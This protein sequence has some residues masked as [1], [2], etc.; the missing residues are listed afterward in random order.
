VT[1]A[2]RTDLRRA[3]LRFAAVFVAVAGTALAIYS[4]PYAEYGLR[5][6]WFHRYLAAYA[7]LA[8]WVL[9]L[10]HADV[11]VAGADV[12][13]A[14]SLTVAKNCDAMDVNILLVA[15]IVA[16]PAAWRR[17]AVGIGLGILA[18]AAINILR[19]VSLYYVGVRFPDRFER[20][21]AELWP[22]V[23]VAVALTTFVLWSRWASGPPAGER[24][25]ARA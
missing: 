6:D 12:V 20:V 23:M 4:F 18:L 10:T 14:V 16:F 8:G 11:S 9:R 25:D 19:I 7:R 5:E 2:R 21:H 24:S 13:G 17:R 3:R 1:A 15:A 22:F